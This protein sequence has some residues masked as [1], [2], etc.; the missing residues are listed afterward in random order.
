[1]SDSL[2]VLRKLEKI[3]RAPARRLE[4]NKLKSAH[5]AKCENCQETYNISAGMVGLP[6]YCPCR[7]L[8]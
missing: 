8:K 3:E 5:F 7:G 6:L 4:A 2:K 1:M